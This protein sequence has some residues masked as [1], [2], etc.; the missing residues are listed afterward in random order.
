M[1]IVVGPI[2]SRASTGPPKEDYPKVCSRR[3]APSPN[4]PSAK[5][6]VS[7]Q[8]MNFQ[9]EEIMGPGPRTAP[10]SWQLDVGAISHSMEFIVFS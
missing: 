6:E 1:E 10:G 8:K 9:Q 3:R 2:Y 7:I 4:Y 5:E